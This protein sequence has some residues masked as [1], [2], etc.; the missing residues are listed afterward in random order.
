MIRS[1]LFSGPAGSGKTTKIQTMLSCLNK[2]RTIEI[3]ME[4]FIMNNKSELRRLY[5]VIAIDPI[6]DDIELSMLS[7]YANRPGFFFLAATQLPIN[8]LSMFH[9]VNLP[10]GNAS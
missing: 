1:I 7:Y 4:E 10:D 6:V 2:K 3:T 8:D 5:D 9:V